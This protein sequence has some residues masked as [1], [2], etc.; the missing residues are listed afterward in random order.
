ML[1]QTLVFKLAE[2]NSSDQDNFQP[3]SLLLEEDDVDEL[4]SELLFEEESSSVLA[5]ELLVVD[6]AELEELELELPEKSISQELR[7]IKQIKI[8]GLI[9]F[10]VCTFLYTN[11]AD[12]SSA[13]FTSTTNILAI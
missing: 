8:K 10:M 1:S 7:L 3:V 5:R 6:S 2:V 13:L 4:A 9:L 12:Y 11:K